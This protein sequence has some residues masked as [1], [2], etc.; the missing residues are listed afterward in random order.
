RLI[1]L[2]VFRG[3]TVAAMIVVNTAGYPKTTY[4][5]LLHAHWNG[6]SP[7]DW[8]FPFFLFIIGVAMTFSL[9]RRLSDGHS[10]A[11]VMLHVLW[12]S[13]ILFVLGVIF[14]NFPFHNFDWHAFRIPGVLQRIG[15]CYFIASFIYLKTGPKGRAIISAALLLGYWA[16]MTLIPV[17][18]VGAGMLSQNFKGGNLGAYI[19]RLLVGNHLLTQTWDPTGF[20]GSLPATVNVLIGTF[21][22]NLLR[23][24]KTPSKK[25]WIMALSGLGLILLGWLWGG[26]PEF[27]GFLIIGE[28]TLQGPFFAINKKIW[29][30]S[31]V[32]YTSGLGCITLALCYLLVDMLEFRAWSL[33]FRVFGMN[34][35]FAFMCAGML[36]A[37]MHAYKLANGY[38]WQEAVYRNVFL[39]IDGPYN[40]SLLYA[41]TFMLF[42]LGL[43]SI[44]YWKKMFIKI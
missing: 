33:P 15:I 13:A 27:N 8:V 24:D 42:W 29:T 36:D 3:I 18:D 43:M 34:S 6:C 25:C 14:S 41:L 39:P 44:L 7:T 37:A 23:S 38:S 4:S 10:H 30:S 32:L 40:A 22:G 21:V 5:M 31:F 2:D 20:F 26:C 28:P 35:I 9:D 1:S 17:P 12:R 11:K 19:D 16:V